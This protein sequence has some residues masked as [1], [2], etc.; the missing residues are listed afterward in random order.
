MMFKMVFIERSWRKRK[1]G[2]DITAPPPR[3]IFI[4]QS[5]VLADKAQDYH[6]K[7]LRTV[8]AETRSLKDS[9]GLAGMRTQAAKSGLYDKDEAEE[10]RE[11]LPK[12]FSELKSHHF[13]LFISFHR[14]CRLLEA[15]MIECDADM[16][17][18]L[19]PSV[20]PSSDFDE[21]D[22]LT[23]NDYM[24]QRRE[25]FVSYNVFLEEY[26]R[27]FPQSLTKG[28]NPVSVFA[29]F[30][31]II[32]GSE[33]AL[34]NREGYL[35]RDSYCALSHRIG[36]MHASKESVYSLFEAYV[37]RKMHRREYDAADRTQ[38]ILQSIRKHGV[39]GEKV[40]FVYVDE[41]QD[42]LLI[43]TLV[44]RAIC[45]RP[46]GL[47]WAGDTAQTISA[48]SSFRFND[49]PA[50][51][52]RVEKGQNTHNPQTFYLNRNFRS[53]AGIVHCAQT[54]LDAIMQIWPYSVDVIAPE[55]GMLDGQTPLFIGGVDFDVPH[56]E[57][58]MCRVDS[59]SGIGNTIEFGDQ[60]CIIVRNEEAREKLRA[61]F[62]DVG[63]IMTLYETKGL[64]FEDVLLYNFFADSTVSAAQWRVVLKG[65][66]V[67]SPTF[68]E[69]KH[70]GVC[71]ELKCLYVACTRARLNLWIVDYSGKGEP[72]RT[73]WQSRNQIETWV[74][75]ARIPVLAQSE[76]SPERW[77]ATAERLFHVSKNYKE[78]MIAYGRA[79]EKYTKERAAAEAYHLRELARRDA[80]NPRKKAAQRHEAYS[81]AAQALQR[82][83][84]DDLDEE[85]RR[86][87][88]RSA[89]ECFVRAQDHIGAARCFEQI[90]NFTRAAECY[91]GGGLFDDAVRLVK[92]RDVDTTLKEK[93]IRVSAVHYIKKR[94]LSKATTLLGSEEAVLE[95][96][97]MYGLDRERASLLE[98][99]NRV[100]EAA[101]LHLENDNLAEAVRLLTPSSA[102]LRCADRIV[103]SFMDRFWAITSLG[104][105]STS[106]AQLLQQIPLARQL[107][108][109]P[110][111]PA[112]TRDLLALPFTLTSCDSLRLR[113][114][115]LKLLDVDAAFALLSL[116]HAFELAPEIEMTNAPEVF[117]YLHAL[118]VYLRALRELVNR[119]DSRNSIILRRL[120]AVSVMDNGSYIVRP[121]SLLH[122]D[123]KPV[124]NRTT[125]RLSPRDLETAMK[126]V[127]RKRILD[128]VRREND[129]CKRS[130]AFSV[131]LQWS[132]EGRCS[133]AECT[134]I[135]MTSYNHAEYQ[136]RVA[137]HGLQ[138]CIYHTL[139]GI[140]AWPT[141]QE[142]QRFWLSRLRET[143]QPAAASLGA[144]HN[145][146]ESS[147]SED[148]RNIVSYWLSEGLFN[149]ITNP[150]VHVK[151]PFFLETFFRSCF[152]HK[153]V[154]GKYIPN[155]ADR[156]PAVVGPNG[157]W[158]LRGKERVDIISD[159]VRL[160]S[161]GLK[162]LTSG[163][164]MVKHIIEQRLPIQAG[165]LC[166]ILDILCPMLV[167]AKRGTNM[168]TLTFPRSWF[169][170]VAKFLDGSMPRDTEIIWLYIKPMAELLEQ[171]YTQA[172]HL[173][174]K[175][176]DGDSQAL[177]VLRSVYILRV[178]RNLCLFGYNIRNDGLR[179]EILK[180]LNSIQQFQIRDN[181]P[182]FP[183]TYRRFVVA[184]RWSELVR[185]VKYDTL[186]GNGDFLVELIDETRGIVPPP[187]A[188]GIRRVVYRHP[189][190]VPA[191]LEYNCTQNPKFAGTEQESRRHTPAEN[192]EISPEELQDVQ[193]AENDVD[194]IQ[195]SDPDSVTFADI[196]PAQ[197]TPSYSDQDYDAIRTA[198]AIYRKTHNALNV[199]K[200][201]AMTK[202]SLLRAREF[203]ACL[204][205]ASRINWVGR[206]GYRMLFLWYLPHV[207]C[208]MQ[209]IIASLHG[210]KAHFKRQVADPARNP[211]E[212]DDLTRKIT[213]AN[214]HNKLAHKLYKDLSPRS[215]FHDRPDRIENLRRIATQIQALFDTLPLN[216]QQEY[217]SDI[218]L[219]LRGILVDVSSTKVEKAELN[220]EDDV[221]SLYM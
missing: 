111:Y 149:L 2:E 34:R 8:E 33:Q 4:T 207:L 78:A 214:E 210:R 106:R 164:L 148:T 146:D 128:L 132:I 16:R 150:G 85:A 199:R 163:I 198:L 65:L 114:Q 31:G 197:T 37:K 50:L 73:L 95:H 35:D 124:A 109:Y 67:K 162:P 194:H 215:E 205:E 48:G 103:Q 134:N 57:Q 9:E 102:G 84:E 18:R 60:Q 151:I 7:V 41:V 58:F 27:H 22:V 153:L 158:L 68:D 135:H 29:E 104:Y 75:G 92:T 74:P 218:T 126:M 5:P 143:L 141:R 30:M 99:L 166:D 26:W 140:E 97:D 123:T 120:L 139:Y 110:K 94:Q 28:L 91:Y 155:N 76:S 87:N 202:A 187:S 172:D 157:D 98:K 61:E 77:A 183:L 113:Q 83:A 39:P 189:S 20:V 147:L 17:R 211:L 185:Y 154:N 79:G 209:G 217:A 38:M 195:I 81:R 13:P 179:Y 12:T 193:I 221:D 62:G 186:G 177:F 196:Q 108:Q 220:W 116:D 105:V 200:H 89:A 23:S 167:L 112:A 129:I 168:H 42:N 145:V 36:T 32:R 122:P 206:P 51:M 72:M 55:K 152:L 71:H 59:E 66:E 43:D 184:K 180:T 100:D 45:R 15:D 19:W 212:Y 156:I 46:T 192:F 138:I 63:V 169:A 1:E 182:P 14:L 165:L 181:K 69:E 121:D 44:L 6:Q 176:S 127:L 219:G 133:V 70:D 11:D 160:L 25:S 130:R 54:V 107:S 53:Q 101:E 203:K 131:C 178:C 24:L 204:T 96:A 88:F 119:P 86:S 159:A 80:A 208:S 161:N 216:I 47:F 213:E 174:L 118:L 82:V 21:D 117:E 191:L 10:Y 64:E 90:P 170:Q 56:F 136:L 144:W 93:V 125:I 142:Q 40:D 188:P 171:L 52:F 201:R 173:R 190:E 49:L 3:Q 115:G 137:L 175:A